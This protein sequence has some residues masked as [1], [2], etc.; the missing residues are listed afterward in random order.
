MKAKAFLVLA[1]ILVVVL[2]A[3]CAAPTAT[4]VP[5]TD[6]PV[7]P[8][9][10]PAPPTPTPTPAPSPTPTQT[11]VRVGGGPVT[12]AQITNFKVEP[13]GNILVIS[14]NYSGKASD[15]NAFHVFVDSDNSA[16]TGYQVGSIGAEF[17]LEN[18][19]LFSY[20][21]DGSSWQWNHVSPADVSFSSAEPTASWT[22]SRAALKLDKAKAAAFVAQLVDINWD[23]AAITPKLVVE[24]K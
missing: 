3:S 2:A 12:S 1:S 7:P 23:S 24:F 14:F 4:P 15:Y 20:A 19:G 18:A 13:Q 17:L 16:N 9:P 21:G 6:T 10:T 8:S 11:P 5:P 22:V